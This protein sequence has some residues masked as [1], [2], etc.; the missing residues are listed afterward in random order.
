MRPG[1][2]RAP[3]PVVFQPSQLPVC[4]KF[5]FFLEKDIVIVP[6]MGGVIPVTQILKVFQLLAPADAA[7]CHPADHLPRAILHSVPFSTTR[8]SLRSSP[9][10]QV[11]T[12]TE[13]GRWGEHRPGCTPGRPGPPPSRPLRPALGPACLPRRRTDQG[14]RSPTDG[15]ASP[16]GRASRRR[17]GGAC[18]KSRRGC[19]DV[20]EDR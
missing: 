1:L 5:L 16:G 17:R 13:G 9:K 10:V 6:G 4:S 20:P 2:A 18:H 15:P 8:P 19:A 11:S 14:S 12:S 7:L 3:N